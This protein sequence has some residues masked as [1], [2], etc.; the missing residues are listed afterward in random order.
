MVV[1]VSSGARWWDL[2]DLVRG[3]AGATQDRPPEERDLWINLGGS[4]YFV[5]KREHLPGMAEVLAAAG[6]LSRLTVRAVPDAA[7]CEHR[8]CRRR[9]GEPAEPGPAKPR[10]PAVRP[11]VEHAPMLGL[12]EVMQLHPHLTYFGVGAYR[13]SGQTPAQWNAEVAEGRTQLVSH[14]PSVVALATWLRENVM[15][16]KTPKVGSYGMKHLVENALGTYVSNGELIA[17]AL[18]ASYPHRYITGPN[19]LL[20][21][22][23]RDIKRIRATRQATG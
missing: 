2:D 12:A 22:S 19:L 17:A 5:T 3:V 13:R 15:P 4:S 1:N 7:H 23:A 18:I 11:S 16:I 20:G 6:A 10:R 9:R 14:E 21:M 8:S